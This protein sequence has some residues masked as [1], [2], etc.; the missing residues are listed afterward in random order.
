MSA[1]ATIERNRRRHIAR[2]GGGHDR[3]VRTLMFVLPIAI[4]VLLALMILA[5]LSPRSEISFLLDRNKVALTENRMTVKKAM[6]RGADDTGRPFSIVAGSALQR[7]REAQLV[8]MD[9][10]T[11][12]IL[13]AEGPAVLTARAGTYALDEERVAVPGEVEFEAADGY[14]IRASNVSVDLPGRRLLGDGR[15][16]GSIPAGTFSADMLR[17]DLQARTISL[18]GNARLRMEPG[19]LR[20]QQ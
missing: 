6:Y 1:Q 7:T 11:A 19:A 2:P 5:P 17:A 8:E 3:L 20:M 12:R 14:R 15:V 13:L 9:E 18:I 4:G 10:L 16:S